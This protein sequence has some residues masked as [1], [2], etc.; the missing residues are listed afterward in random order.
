VCSGDRGP[1]TKTSSLEPRLEVGTVC[2]QAFVKV[3]VTTG[4]SPVTKK[5]PFTGLETATV[6]L[7]PP[8]CP[9]DKPPSPPGPGGPASPEGPGGPRSPRH[10][11]PRTS[12]P[13]SDS[14]SLV[15][16]GPPVAGLYPASP[17][18]RA[19][20]SMGRKAYVRRRKECAAPACQPHL[21]SL[22]DRQAGAEPSLQPRS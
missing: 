14:P 21:T 19:S 17:A 2:P 16:S 22:L 7:S 11:T 9:H 4:R 5:L 10:P 12:I 3:M 6:T 1:T 15:T 18:R 8:G 20:S 13:S